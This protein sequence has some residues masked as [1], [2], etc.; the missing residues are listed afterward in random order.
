MVWGAMCSSGVLPLVKINGIMLKEHYHTILARKAI[1]GGKNLLGAG[2][3]FQQD[4]DP[5]HTALIKKN[6]LII[7]K[8]KV[9]IFII[10]KGTMV[11]YSKYYY[12]FYQGNV[13]FMDWPPQSPDLNPI[14]QLWDH[15]DRMLRKSPPISVN[16]AWEKLSKYWGEIQ[17]PI[18][19]NYVHSMKRRCQ[20][21]ID[22]KG[23]HTK[24]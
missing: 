20:A 2:F 8:R 9:N 4:N 1:P 7:K 10:S 14:E 16:D 24:Y 23:G 11:C 22:A 12:F 21:V 13:V 15:L 17:Q 3:C 6:I 18:L 19:Q 5:K